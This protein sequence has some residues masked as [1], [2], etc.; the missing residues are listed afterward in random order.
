MGSPSAGAATLP[1][2]S[3]AQAPHGDQEGRVLVRQ[4]DAKWTPGKS[5]WTTAATSPH[6]TRAAPWRG[7]AASA[8]TG[9]PQVVG[10]QQLEPNASTCWIAQFMQSA[11]VTASH[12]YTG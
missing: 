6:G 3:L 12:E 11:T 4:V 7:A 8:Q 2:S 10:L 1:P 5:D 9:S